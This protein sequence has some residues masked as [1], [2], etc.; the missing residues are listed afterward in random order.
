MM[1]LVS[2][3]EGPQ[4]V[5]VAARSRIARAKEGSSAPEDWIPSGLHGE[6]APV[7]ALETD[8]VPAEPAAAAELGAELQRL[9]RE[10]GE[11]QERAD[12]E[13]SRAEEAEREAAELRDR[14]KAMKRAAARASA[15]ANPD[16][17]SEDPDA[18]LDLNLATFEQL[19]DAG[20][21]V[22]Q[23]ARVVG[24]REQH[25]GFESV[26]EVDGIVGLPRDIKQALK[27]TGTV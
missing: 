16:E 9:R 26:D 12:A 10:L 17:G 6:Q 20:L 19:R 7:S 3:S 2:P 25:G 4:N 5:R 18:P 13:G 1:G 8:A 21:S 11:A 27:D 14:I 23:A 22:T 15:A 24:Q